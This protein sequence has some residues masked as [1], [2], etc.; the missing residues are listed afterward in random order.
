MDACLSI[1]KQTLHPFQL[2]D[3]FRFLVPCFQR[4]FFMLAGIP[5]AFV[6][7]SG[8]LAMNISPSSRARARTPLSALI[9]FVSGSPAFAASLHGNSGVSVRLRL[10]AN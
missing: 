4:T 8:A 1:E 10:T 9:F 5:P 2:Q 7:A 3:A 6:L